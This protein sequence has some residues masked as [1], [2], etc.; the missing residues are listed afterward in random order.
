MTRG[1]GSKPMQYYRLL[2]LTVLFPYFLLLVVGLTARVRWGHWVA[3][4]CLCYGIGALLFFF[5]YVLT[6]PELRPS[7]E[8]R[9]KRLATINPR[10]ARF[11]TISLSV[12][13]LL[14]CSLYLFLMNQ[15]PM[16]LDPAHSFQ[17]WVLSRSVAWVSIAVSLVVLFRLWQVYSRKGKS[18]SAS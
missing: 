8:E 3:P 6:R 16:S 14:L 10:R 4:V 9:A 13:T 12:V 15:P 18:E 7:A 11:I 2:A 5:R 1:R 17:I